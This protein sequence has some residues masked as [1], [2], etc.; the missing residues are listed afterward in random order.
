MSERYR[1][2]AFS[3]RVFLPGGDPD[4]VKIVEKSNWTGSGLVIPRSLFAE[5][6]VRD[7]LTRAGVYILAPM[8]ARNY[9]V[10][11]LV[12]ATRWA[13]VW[14]HTGAIRISGPMS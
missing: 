5:T 11:T 12:K 1:P 13:R 4:G 8:P 3:V 2:R 9:H 7:E 10:C 6:R 14:I